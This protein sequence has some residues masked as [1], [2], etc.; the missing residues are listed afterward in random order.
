M[1]NPDPK[2]RPHSARAIALA[3]EEIKKIDR[4][5]KAAVSQ[6]TSGFNALTAGQDKT[7]ARRLLGYKKKTEK[8]TSDVP[9]FQRAGFQ[10]TALILIVALT[11]F[12]LIPPSHE[13]IVAEATAMVESD[14]PAL[15]TEARIKLERIMEGQ[16]K[17]AEQAEELF[18]VSSRKSLVEHAENGKANRLQ[19]E[20]VQLFGKAV[21]HQLV[22]EEREAK[23]IY[24]QLVATVDPEGTERHVYQEAR[25]RLDALRIKIELP[26]EPEIL[27]ELIAQTKAASTPGQLL[28]AHELLG[29]I[30]LEFAGED[31]YEETVRLASEELETV[32][33]RIKGELQNPPEADVPKADVPEEQSPQ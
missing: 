30:A 28:E 23:E 8:K 26:P 31:G 19:S 24:S 32:K 2:K 14:D 1:L 21:R 12:A 27:S 11:V 17:F 22:G 20:N 6:M 10:I 7:E 25:E 4:T 13:K 18:Y 16:G 9:F 5:K 15:W 29:R 3:F 33:L